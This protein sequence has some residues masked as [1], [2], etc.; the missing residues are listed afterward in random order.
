MLEDADFYEKQE[1]IL[2][3]YFSVYGN[4]KDGERIK[5]VSI[6]DKKKR[7]MVV[8]EYTNNS[9]EF[10][11]KEFSYDQIMD[12]VIRIK[13]QMRYFQE[14]TMSMLKDCTFKLLAQATQDSNS[15]DL[16][17]VFQ[18][19]DIAERVK[20]MNWNSFLSQK[21]IEEISSIPIQIRKIAEQCG[22]SL[23]ETDYEY[24]ETSLRELKEK[25]YFDFNDGEYLEVAVEY[26]KSKKLKITDK[27]FEQ[28]SL[29][30]KIEIICNN[31][32]YSDIMGIQ[33]R[34]VKESKRGKRV[35][36]AEEEEKKLANESKMK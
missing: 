10:Y 3:Q 24:E 20:N 1:K 17:S 5:E 32:L 8:V 11:T 7:K 36:A 13:K 12:D 15:M 31:I 25:E 23:E 9:W 27:R 34:V 16:S 18:M 26:L 28:L 22:V 33:L 29:E 19:K 30:K 35:K 21:Q 4:L 14:N 6:V 2:Y